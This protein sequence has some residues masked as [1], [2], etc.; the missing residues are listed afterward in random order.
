V[1]WIVVVLA[2]CAYSPT[3]A[4][5]GD[6][7]PEDGPSTTQDT[8]TPDVATFVCPAGF[9]TLAGA[10]SKYQLGSTLASYEQ[11]I[12]ACAAIDSRVHLARVD[13]QAEVDALFTRAGDLMRV[14][15]QRHINS[16][17]TTAD[18]TWHDLDDVTELTFQPW[19]ADEPTALVGE[20]CMSIR[21]EFTGN[22]PP[23]VAGADNC[24]TPRSFLCEC[25]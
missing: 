2:G 23:I 22:P 9:E 5:T 11:A 6:D 19:G 18:D 20:L 25:E 10:P 4:L 12:Q 1:S 8:V 13:S 7:V 21:E 16:P 17:A 24:T 14:V 3:P 15:G